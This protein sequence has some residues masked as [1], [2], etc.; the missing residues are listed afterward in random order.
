MTSHRGEHISGARRATTIAKTLI[1]PSAYVGTAREVVLGAASLVAY[2]LGISPS[3]QPEPVTYT[4]RRVNHKPLLALDADV[5]WTPII[6]VHGYIHNRS[7]FLMMSRALR[8]AGFRYVHTMNYNPLAADM[9]T[10]ATQLGEE[11]ERVLD[12]TGAERVQLVGHSMGGMVARTYVQMYGGAPHV[13]T[14]A[15]LGSPHRGTWSALLGVGPAAAELR[16][17]SPFLRHLEETARP[18]HV[19]WLSYYSDLDAMIIPSSSGKLVHPALDAVNI[20]T[21]DTGHLSL[22][23]HGEVLRSIVTHLSDPWLGRPNNSG[24]ARL[25]ATG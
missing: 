14:V 20:K 23:M 16:P 2:P 12:A 11:V 6:L 24:I 19:R 1:R 5:A 4:P 13:D 9:G 21:R 3:I 8:R 22:L 10:L 17:R 18:S 25:R 7:A 15:T